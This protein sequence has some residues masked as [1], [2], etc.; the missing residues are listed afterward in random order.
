MKRAIRKLILTESKSHRTA[1]LD[2]LGE[3]TEADLPA[4][5][6]L[7]ECETIT[8]DW[9]RAAIHRTIRELENKW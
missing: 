2:A 4:L 6:Q 1:V 3:L 7:V 9:R 8:G 5:R